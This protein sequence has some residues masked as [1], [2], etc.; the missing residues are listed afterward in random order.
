[1]SSSSSLSEAFRERG[2]YGKGA[3]LSTHG[4]AR[5][6]AAD[7]EVGEPQ[8]ETAATVAG[9]ESDV[10]VEG[11]RNCYEADRQDVYSLEQ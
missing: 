9:V 11:A 3:S 2:L 10:R 1:M 7:A 4:A 5:A 6:S 8:S